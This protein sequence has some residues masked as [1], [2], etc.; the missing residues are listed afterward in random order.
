MGTNFSDLVSN[1]LDKRSKLSPMDFALLTQ[2]ITQIVRGQTYQQN[3]MGAQFNT[4]Y[5]NRYGLHLPDIAGFF[6]D[7][8]VL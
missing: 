6:N 2:Q 3:L 4:S 5:G 7:W 1:V 8:L